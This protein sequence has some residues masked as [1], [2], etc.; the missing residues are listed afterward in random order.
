MTYHFLLLIC[1]LPKVL[2]VEVPGECFNPGVQYAG[3]ALNEP[4]R[5]K[6]PSAEACQLFCQ[7]VFDC[8]DFSWVDD[9]YSLVELRLGCT[10]WSEVKVWLVD[11]H[12]I[13]GPREC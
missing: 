1:L 3:V 10:L 11:K 2:L 9:S 7:T 6:T 4:E 12:F 13:S 8:T 5:D